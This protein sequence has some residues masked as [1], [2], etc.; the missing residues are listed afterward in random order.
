VEFGAADANG[1]VLDSNASGLIIFDHSSQFSG[2]ISGLNFDDQLDLRDVQFGSSNSLSYAD[3][4]DGT[5]TLTVSD[6]SNTVQLH[7]IGSYQTADFLLG[8]DARGGLLI[9]NHI[10]E[11]LL[12]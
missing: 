2:T 10:G 4:G 3:N 7:L 11:P 8:A 1:V 6:G 9:T 5:G 12:G